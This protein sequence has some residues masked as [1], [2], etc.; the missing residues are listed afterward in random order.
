M[1]VL[2]RA[3]VLAQSGLPVPPA[4]GEEWPA[5][6]WAAALVYL[7]LVV[8][9]LVADLAL[10]IRLIRRPVDW[11]G[12]IRRIADRPWS[13]RQAAAPLLLLW[14]LYVA[15]SFLQPADGAA[16]VMGVS[17][18]N[19][20]LIAQSLLF[21]V[22]GLA[23][24]AVILRRRG[25][26]WADAFGARRR[27]A[28]RAAGAGFVGYLAAM[29]LLLFYTGVYQF[30]LKAAGMD[31][32]PQGVTMAFTLD[33]PLWVRAYLFVLAIALAPLL[34]EVLFRGM[35]LPLL[36]RRWGA[37]AA[38]VVVSV[39]FALIHFHV[40]SLVPLFVVAAACSLAYIATGSIL[41]PVALHGIFNAVNLGLLM[42]IQ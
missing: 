39:L 9:G 18:T 7:G 22:G 32:Q 24:V 16:A 15:A 33:D 14:S 23:T 2:S 21:H 6:A 40:P 27:A 31:V 37:G 20:F 38:V 8:L 13:P 10:M 3:L 17:R 28:V 36:L 25:I 30:A 42:V 5:G 4:A 11:A 12:R 1:N 29:P 41:V 26:G 35:L 34:E 19:L